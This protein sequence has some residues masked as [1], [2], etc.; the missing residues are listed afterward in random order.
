MNPASNT[1]KNLV[2]LFPAHG[3]EHTGMTKDLY[4]HFPRYREVLDYCADCLLDSL[5]FDLRHLI[6]PPHGREEYVRSKLCETYVVQ[7]ALFAVEYSLARFLFDLGIS[8]TSMLGYSVG[9]FTAACLA[10]V[11]SLEDG[12]KLVTERGRLIQS[13]PAGS[14]L[15]VGL[16]EEDCREL[17]NDSISLATVLEDNHCV[18]SG[19]PEAITKLNIQ[20]RAQ[21]VATKELSV[22]HAFHSVMMDPVVDPFKQIISEVSLHAP[23]IPYIS[24][25]SGNH[26]DEK[27]LTTNYWANHLRHTIRWKDAITT[28]AQD[29][30]NLFLEV[31]PN[32]LIASLV[33]G[34][35]ALKK[36]QRVFSICNPGISNQ[37]GIQNVLQVL[38]MLS[39]EGIDVLWT[40]LGNGDTTDI[41]P[42]RKLAEQNT[43]PRDT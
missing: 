36:T 43:Q 41:T 3:S 42:T 28:L 11:F 12:L 25:V 23:K 37:S 19:I 13:L 5:D 26:I 34:N 14:M 2:F 35:P 17:E 31:G 24:C 38:C 15:A 32:N 9:E 29:P 1:P 18:L 7:P 6:A 33:R 27:V 20:L 21:K 39:T 30:Q 4:D 10:G 16:S 22:S 8:P 40:A